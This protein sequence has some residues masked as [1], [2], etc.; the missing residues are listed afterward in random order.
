MKFKCSFLMTVITLFA[1]A[2]V[3]RAADDRG[4]GV[5]VLLELFTSEGCSSCPPADHLLEILDEEQSVAGADLIV[6]S[7]HVDYWDRLGWRD[8]FLPHSTPRASRTTR[9]ATTSMEFIH[10]SLSL[11]DDTVSWEATDARRRPLFKKRFGSAR[12]R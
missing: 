11:T 10:H 5:P 2:L 8:R 12:F 9:T 6:L 3:C 7:E 1:G 4:A